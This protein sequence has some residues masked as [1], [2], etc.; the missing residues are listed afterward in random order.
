MSNTL[1]RRYWSR[2]FDRV[3]LEKIKTAW[4][5]PW[6][7]SVWYQGGLTATPHCNLVSN[8]GFGEDGA[9]TKKKGSEFEN[10][11]V[12][13]LGEL[14]HPK[15]V[16]QHEEADNYVF[17]HVFGGKYQGLKRLP[18]RVE[19]KLSKLYSTLVR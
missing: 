13:C 12:E 18:R 11:S 10:M 3:Y 9:H 5:Y 14:T 2:I 15:I 7:A 16:T 1:E 8:T 6:T 4:D 17:Q 19:H